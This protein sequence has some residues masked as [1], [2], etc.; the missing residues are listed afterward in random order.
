MES[1]VLTRLHASLATLPDPPVLPPEAIASLAATFTHLPDPRRAASVHYPLA[2]LL[3]LAVAA[4]LANHLSLLAI[5]AW[6]QRQAPDL[7]GRLGLIRGRA[8]WQS[9]YQRLFRRLD[10]DAVSGALSAHFAVA[11]PVPAERGAEG[12]ALD[13]KAQRG[14]LQFQVGGSPVH[15]LSAFSHERGVVL[16]QEPIEVTADKAE[17][18][19]TVAPRLVTR[20][21]WPGRVLTGD[22]QF[23]QRALCQQVVAA[24]GDYLVIVKANQPHL[25]WAISRLF[26]PTLGTAAPLPLLDRRETRT[27]E[28]GHGRQNEVRHLLASTDLTDYLDWPGLAQV[29]RVER[30]WQERG[31]RKRQVRYAITSLPPAIGTPARLL[32]LKRGHWRI[33]NRLHRPKDVTL[34]EDASLVHVGHGP[35]ILAMLR[36]AAISLLHRAGVRALTARLREH[37][38]H[39]EAAVALVCNPPPTHA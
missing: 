7:L 13:G 10:P 39:P 32:A 24:G 16:A 14:R 33:E 38:Q 6:G 3:A 1:M 35:T 12:V 37:S 30:T 20:I 21:A 22:A 28:C 17:A 23:C 15:A 18:E 8:P 11:A 25:H 31:Q 4:I 5:A 34:G 27:V 9:T 19:L 26:D 2:A 29:V 36:D